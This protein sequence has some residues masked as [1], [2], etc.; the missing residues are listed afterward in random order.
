MQTG[1][2]CKVTC[3]DSEPEANPEKTC[4]AQKIEMT[5]QELWNVIEITARTADS[6]PSISGSGWDLVGWGKR[7]KMTKTIAPII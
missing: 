4:H 7:T 1:E 6:D 5:M 3:C 2:R